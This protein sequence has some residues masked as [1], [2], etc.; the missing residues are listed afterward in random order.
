MMI[1]TK[2]KTIL[3][4]IEVRSISFTSC[5]MLFFCLEQVHYSESKSIGSNPFPDSPVKYIISTQEINNAKKNKKPAHP[6]P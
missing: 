6:Q 1:M 3:L 4:N 2:E 5:F